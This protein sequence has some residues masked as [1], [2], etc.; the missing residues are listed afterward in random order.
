[1]AQS[2]ADLELAAMNAPPGIL[3]PNT[4]FESYIGH[5]VINISNYELNEHQLK[6]LEKGLT[7]CP[8]PPRPDKSEIWNDFKEFHRRLELAQFFKPTNENIDLEITQS[9]IDFM[10]KNAEDEYEDITVNNPYNEIHQKFKNKSRWKPNPP[11]KTLDTFKR[12]FKM[13]LLE[14][15]FNKNPLQNITKDERAGMRDLQNNPHI[16]I[17]KADKGS[18]VVIMNTTDYLREGYRQLSDGNFYTKLK[19]DPTIDLSKKICQVLT[20]MKNVNLITEKN[21]NYLNID[22]PKSGRFYLLPKIHKKGIPG[23]PICSSIDH[24]TCNISKFID[25]HIKD[26]VPKTASYVR[27]TQHF[28]SRLKTL[29]KLPEGALLV[30]LDVSSLYTNIPNREGILAVAAHLRRDRTKDPITPFLLKL[31]ELVL[32]SMNFTFNEEHYLQVG[33]TAMGT[34]VAPN[35]A[36][37]FMDRFETKALEKWHLKPLLWLRF[38]D[39]IFMIWT[40]GRDELNK[41]INYLNSIHPKI[42]FTSEINDTHVNFLDTTVKV[43]ADRS[44]YTTLYEKP[45][46]THLYLHYQSA[47]H[48]PCHQKGPFGQFLRIRRICT[49]NKDF[50]DNGMKMIE[51]YMKRGYPFK[52]LKKHM[53]RASRYTQ[54]DLL[55]VKTKEVTTTPVMTT[56]FNPQN[57]DIKGFIHDNWNII[58][59]SNDCSSTFPDKPI[60]GFKRLPNL[61]DMLTKASI[62]YPPK[63]MVRTKLIPTHC[64]RLGKCTYCPLI[65]KISEITCNISGDKYQPKNLL[66]LISCELSDIVYLITCKKCGKYYVGETG[67]A[68]RQR[69]YEHRLSVNKPKDNRVTPV[70]KHFTGKSHSI[71]DMQFSILEWCTPK[72]NTPST[73]HRRRR[74]QW[75]MWNIGAVHPTGINQFI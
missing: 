70:S 6:V 67:R 60:I 38:I 52:T 69:I 63:E 40:H 43:D 50:I 5:N 12:A 20:D 36:N 33:G 53:L 27:D 4:K 62:S 26:Y 10:N 18:A 68:F 64:T 22:N 41:F 74:E 61:R 65:T 11:N 1:M 31:L 66:K 39:D 23:R 56:T 8:T 19:D 7:F 32:H 57:P 14:C 21:F 72:Y 54:D 25:A 71:K 3:P 45:T 13:N 37:L 15:K 46:D 42:K 29:D 16:V 48:K 2:K 24:P 58:Q 28:I 17:K 51:H 55:E 47:H 30:T 75:W 59:H 49:K 9:I 35:Y 44:I 73:A 34:A